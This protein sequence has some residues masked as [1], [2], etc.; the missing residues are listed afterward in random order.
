MRNTKFNSKPKPKKRKRGGLKI[1]VPSQSDN[2]EGDVFDREKAQRA[3]SN[4]VIVDGER[5]R[6]FIGDVNASR[7]NYVQEN[8]FTMVISLTL[9]PVNEPV[10]GVSYHHFPLND[11]SDVESIQTMKSI[12]A[13]T[14]EL[15]KAHL[16][17]EGN[18]VLVH[19]HAGI[20]RSA[21]VV[22][23]YMMKTYEY[24]YQDARNTLRET[25]ACVSPNIGFIMLLDEEHML[26]REPCA[27]RQR[28]L[29]QSDLD[30]GLEVIVAELPMDDR[31][32]P[33]AAP[34]TARAGEARAFPAFTMACESQ[35]PMA[36]LASARAGE[37]TAFPAFTIPVEPQVPMTCPMAAL[38]SARAGEAKAFPAFTIPVEPQDPMTFP[39]AALASARASEARAFP[40]IAIPAVTEGST[41]GIPSPRCAAFATPNTPESQSPKFF[42]KLK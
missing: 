29:P 20:S 1:N 28:T 24:S 39:T 7:A 14:S 10:E 25:R 9:D 37:A 22:L 33:M 21:T 31:A 19:C 4:E 16:S 5:T 32:Y 34:T 42:L 11:A 15:I 18:N 41:T 30:E 8:Q 6:L 40:A 12:L 17:N 38:A 2:W 35:I 26:D 3:C 36:E 27:K 23:D 13:Q